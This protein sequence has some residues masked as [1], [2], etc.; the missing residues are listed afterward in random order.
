MT[1]ETRSH[2]F[3]GIQEFDNRLPNWWLWTFYLA[4]IFSVFYW[5]HFQTLR[6]G[7]LPMDDYL[8]EQQVAA[9]AMEAQLKA[10][11]VTDEM[12]IK[13]SSNPVFVAEGKAL[14]ENPMKCAQCHRANGGAG[15]NA[16]GALGAGA[17][18][19][20]AYWIYGSTP[21]DI[22][23][24]ILKGRGEDKERGTMGG[25]PEHAVEGLGFVQR[26]TAYVLTLKNT[27]VPGGKE[28]ETY[29]KKSQ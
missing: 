15:A 16:D 10:N 23:N 5:I 26:V 6:T 4:C 24:T 17:N 22:Y 12:L 27:N 20:D 7:N 25:M 28:H 8:E 3:D 2:T 11:P 29:A 13:L 21:M 1:N 18:L 9:E 19:T 14:F